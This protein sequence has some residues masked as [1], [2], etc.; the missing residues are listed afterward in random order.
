MGD[1]KTGWL[2]VASI[3]ALQVLDR[4]RGAATM[5]GVALRAGGDVAGGWCRGGSACVWGRNAGEMREIRRREVV[6][7]LARRCVRLV[8]WR[9]VFGARCYA[10]CIWPVLW[11]TIG[12][13]VGGQDLGFICSCASIP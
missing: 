4:A 6:F 8:I 3:A 9:T 10:A 2:L 7:T 1:R 5:Q 12:G 11:G 13:N